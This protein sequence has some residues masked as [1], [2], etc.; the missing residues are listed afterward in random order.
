LFEV[1]AKKSILKVI[2]KIDSKRKEKLKDII[3]TLKDN[4]VPV[5]V[6]DVAKLKG[7]DS[8]YRI[9]VGSLRLVYEVCWSDK[10]IIIHK[11]EQRESV[12]ENI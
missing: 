4:P 12:Y 2:N 1:N 7:Y 5:R 10:K 11:V 3:M 9:R 6:Y 8:V